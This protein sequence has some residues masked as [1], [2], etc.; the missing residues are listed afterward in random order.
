MTGE[1]VATNGCIVDATTKYVDV[2]CFAGGY[3]KGNTCAVR[4]EDGHVVCWG[5][6]DSRKQISGSP[7]GG[8][9]TALAGGLKH[10]CALR[11]EDKRAVCWG[12]DNNGKTTPPTAWGFASISSA[13]N[14]DYTCGSMDSSGGAAIDTGNS[15]AW[16]APGVVCWGAISTVRSTFFSFDFSLFTFMYISVTVVLRLPFVLYTCAIPRIY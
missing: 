2:T 9:Y 4:A 8:G 5:A 12:H 11:G 10:V 15:G 16:A 7:T 14:S 13:P 6:N 3:L 1:G